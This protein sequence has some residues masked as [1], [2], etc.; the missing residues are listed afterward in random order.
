MA[1]QVF[2]FRADGSLSMTVTP[3]GDG[4]RGGVRIARGDITGDGIA[5]LI[6]ATGPGIAARVRVWD[7]ASAAMLADFD[8]FPGYQ[9]GL[10][11]AAGDLNADRS[12]DIAIGTDLGN[13]PHVKVF[14]GRGQ[15]ELA[16]FYAYA[17]GFLGGVRVGMG[18]LNRDGYADIVTGAGYGAGPHVAMFDGKSI[19]TG[20]GPRK[21]AN[22]FFIFSPSMTAGLNIAVGDV[23]GDGY[24]DVIAAPG[25]GSAHLR[26]AS[27]R[28]LTTGQGEVDL[29]S[30]IAWTGNTSGLR[31]TAV[32]ADGDGRTDVMLAPGGPNNG[33]VGLLAS[34]NLL[35]PAPGN[36]R[37]FDPLPG[38]STGVYV[39]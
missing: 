27:G 10:W 34:A 21:L 13:V 15:V 30:T 19:A 7:G 39:G 18:D 36:I 28:G 31:V 38:L 12:A 25:V 24:A 6:T 1:T 37:W 14:S 35:P 20:Q 16:S 3:F 4:Y 22:D 23:D 17:P 29:V 5:D 8:P 2:V 9:G 11:V 32:D 33:R 26:I